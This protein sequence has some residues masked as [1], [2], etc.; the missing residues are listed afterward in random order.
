MGHGGG[1]SGSTRRTGCR[2]RKGRLIEMRASHELFDE[3]RERETRSYLT[4]SRGNEDR[5][6]GK[7]LRNAFQT[8][9]SVFDL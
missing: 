1:G 5:S 3:P 6:R 9:A 7:N 4:L 8:G 2:R